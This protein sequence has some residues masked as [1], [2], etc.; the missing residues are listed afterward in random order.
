MPASGLSLFHPLIQKWFSE[1]I[2]TP[3]DVQEQA[4]PEIAKGGHVLVTA[5][6]GCGKTL[7]AFLWGVNQLVTHAWPT[8]NVRVLYISPLKALNNDVQRNLLKPLS[9]LRELF[10]Q[11]G[12]PFPE[13][14][15]LTRSGD[16]PGEERRRMIR[17]PPEILITTP[18]SLNLLLTSRSGRTLLTGIATVILDEIHAVVGTKRGTH[19]IT[20]VDRLVPICGEFQRIALSA[21]VNPP[22]RVAEFVAGFRQIGKGRDSHYEKREIATIRSRL[23]KALEFTV[24]FPADAREKMVDDSWWPALID[25]FKKLIEKHRSTLFFANSR[26]TTEKVTRMINEAET[27]ELAYAHHGS[28]ARE[29]RLAVEQKLKRGELRAIVAT[30]SLELGIDIG[31][32]DSVVLIQTPRSVSST[33]QRIGRSGHSVGE[34]SR[35]LLFPLHGRDFVDAAVAARAVLD[36]DIEETH[37]VEAPLD[38]LAQIILSMTSMERW[39]IDELYAFIKTSWPFRN[40]PRKHFDLL[41]DMFSG[42]YADTRLRELKARVSLDKIDNTVQAHRE[43]PYLLY[44]SG[45]TIP[46]RG[47]FDMRLKDTHAKI[48]ELDEEFVWERSI[49]ETFTLGSQLWRIENITHNDVD[50]VPAKTA[51]GIFPFW[52]AEEQNR[53][54]HFSERIGYFL[55]HADE[56]LDDPDFKQE[57]RTRHA[58]D[59]TAADELVSFLKLQKEA[60]GS[61]LP[62]RHHILVEYLQEPANRG[63]LKQVIVHTFWGGRVNRPFALALAEAWEEKEHKPLPIIQDDDSLLLMLPHEVGIGEILDLLTTENVEAYLRKRL[64]KTGFFGARFRENAERAL[65]LPKSSFKRR[66][67]LWLIR[68]RSKE[69]MEA[70]RPYEDFPILLETWRTCLEDEFDLENLK[71]VIEE[72]RDSRISVTGTVLRAASPFA[73]HLVWK[74]TNKYMYEDDTPIL[75]RESAL[76]PELIQEILFSSHLRPK[77]PAEVI[78]VLD[79]KL[80]RTAAGYAPGS[81]VELLDWIKERVL[82]PEP[83]WKKLAAAIRR[84]HD[85]DAWSWLKGQA[86][87]TAWISWPGVRYQ[88]LC[89]LEIIPKVLIAFR[90]LI[91]DLG[92]ESLSEEETGEGLRRRIKKIS[93]FLTLPAPLTSGEDIQKKE[94]RQKHLYPPGGE[95]RG[96]PSNDAPGGGGAGAGDERT[97][98]NLSDLL[99]EWLAFYGPVEK[100]SLQHFLGVTTAHLDEA[101]EPLVEAQEVVLDRFGEESTHLEVCDSRNLEMLLRMTRRYRRPS[102]EALP[103]DQLPLFLAGYQGLAR[104]GETMDAL[105]ER[106][107]Q[108]FGWSAP[109]DA[110]EE[111]I[112]PSRMQDYRLE[113]LDRLM[114][115]T[116]LRWVGSGKERI[117]LAFGQ[118]LELFRPAASGRAGDGGTLDRLI[119]DRRGRYSLLEMSEFS[120]L[121][122]VQTTEQLWKEAWKGNI[123]SDSFRTVRRGAMTGFTAPAISDEARLASRRS[124]FNRWKVSRPVEGHWQRIDPDP[125]ERDV[126]EEQELMKD[127][128]RQL[129]KRYGILFRELLS[130]E[131]PLLQWRA[132]FRAL[133]IMELSGEIVSGYF[134][135]G[136][137]G[138]QFMSHEAF[139]LVQKPLHEDTVYWLN[140]ADPASL[141][142]LSPELAKGLPPRVASTFLVYHGP[143]LVMI[144]K[145]T[146]KSIDL[147]APPDKAGLQDYFLVFKDLL[148]REFNP[149]SKIIVE[150][151][152]GEPVQRSPYLAQLKE[153]GFRSARNTVELWKQY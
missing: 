108:L 109:A 124:G 40:L 79:E 9:E 78:S 116:D 134:F 54:F 5:P 23:A 56:R 107:E 152:N 145:R 55:E 22:E 73:S 16:T 118:D 37:P 83:E 27:A 98:Y 99:S 146:G 119:P 143:R 140:A 60:T 61:S 34:T 114:A 138:L 48:G 64:E 70:V 121:D 126:L 89:S 139:R 12:E 31:S 92:V 137:S 69:L 45:G 68:L 94:L 102:F 13:V 142:G 129:L 149:P 125:G 150:T 19:L 151:V 25:A 97:A 6:T 144:A 63:E 28:L 74:Q 132:V 135:E 127:R 3:T 32:L 36:Q 29:I 95:G 38:I 44:T 15:V 91:E 46:E 93:T 113:W 148:M 123:T 52:K 58:M 51:T 133:R 1:N 47:Y 101:V 67:P 87:K 10:S 85:A 4:W 111:Y 88:L 117:S 8:G 49:G 141:C 17:K 59:G 128:S 26:R 84:D 106:L 131:I 75:A 105:Q 153:F 82:I 33:L 136:I 24:M 30:N 147:F 18:E 96:L 14:S 86:K 43:V 66:M 53:D 130:N 11:A 2:G 57:L 50:V 62:H 104:R 103:F 65:L 39:D 7:T 77:I 80:K 41:L 112:L 81:D 90:L 72:V 20:A 100:D 21:T 115:E 71:L 42:R 110:W 120:H 122:T 35:G 76:R